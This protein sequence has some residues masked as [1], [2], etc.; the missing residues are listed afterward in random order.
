MREVKPGSFLDMEV[1]TAP[2]IMGGKPKNKKDPPP[3][4]VAR[5][6]FLDLEKRQET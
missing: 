2:P 4:P 6:G 5:G 1:L 3:D